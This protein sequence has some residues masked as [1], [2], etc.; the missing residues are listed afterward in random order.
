[1]DF[2]DKRRLVLAGRRTGLVWVIAVT[3]TGVVISHVGSPREVLHYFG[4]TFPGRFP[5]IRHA[6]T[7]CGG[8]WSSLYGGEKRSE[9]MVLGALGFALLGTARS[10]RFRE[11]LRQ[12]FGTDEGVVTSRVEGVTDPDYRWR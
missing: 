11:D 5:V 8:S 12:V 2:A 9:A 6:R 10:G 4:R 7:F 1:M 3:H